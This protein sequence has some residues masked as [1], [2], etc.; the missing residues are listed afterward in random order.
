LLATVKGDVHDIGKNI[1]GVVL[2]CN[3]FEIIDLGVMVPA[4]T[5]IQTA[6]EQQ[7]DIIGLSGLITPSLDEMVHIA[8]ELTRLELDFPLMIG[9][10]TT[11]RAHTAVK[12]EPQYAHTAVYV[13][14]ASR[15]VGV[16]AKLL[17]KQATAYG[18]EIKAEY[19]Q[20]RQ[21][22]ARTGQRN[23]LISFA[24]A[25][26]NKARP[27]WSQ[28]TPP[29]P[30]IL[31]Q[32]MD[33]PGLQRV[34]S[35]AGHTLFVFE[36]YSLD[37]LR[38]YIDWTPFFHAWELKG[39]YPKILDDAHKGAQARELFSD[40]QE[41]LDT[42][43]KENWLR[44]KAVF[45]FFP[46]AGIDESIQIYDESRQNV[47]LSLQH[48]RQ[49]NRRPE[50][51]ANQCLSDWIAPE[52]SGLNDYIGAFAVTTGVGIEKHVAR[53]EADH[54]DYNAI[55]LKILADRLAEAFA[56]RLHQRVRTEFWGYAAAESMNNEQ[57][58]DEAYQGIRPAPGYPACPDH[59]E[60]AALW[61]LLEAD[62]RADISIT[63]SF[64]MLPAASVSG[65]YF[66]HPQS[67]YFGV[68]QIDQDQLEAYAAQ[69]DMPLEEARRWL[70]P[71]LR[72]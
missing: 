5:I 66:A 36:N 62:S 26:A 38:E 55:M 63:E 4:S 68:G 20:V 60:K 67:R 33:V 30:A 31:Q 57:L 40:A 39:R 19:E 47:S 52:S 64:A 7:V 37:D 18:A 1:V 71:S 53:F 65:W 59:T 69:K 51:K 44:A 70:A 14:D 49:Q 48:L 58:I 32:P 9:G 34:Q 3:N 23:R 12:I 43:I 28:F 72:S 16:A 13:K 46:A 22:R 29:K 10:A 56:E 61:K 25:R 17:G 8:S 15:A 42:L 50:G 54:D 21:Q 35:S 6:V 45:G 2:Q 11:S 24:Q 27:D 41:M